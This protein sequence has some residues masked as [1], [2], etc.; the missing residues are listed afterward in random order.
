ME[1]HTGGGGGL[2]V[3]VSTSGQTID[4]S[5][6]RPADPRSAR[7][8]RPPLSMGCRPSVSRD[9]TFRGLGSASSAAG[10][11]GCGKTPQ[12]PPPPPRPRG[13]DLLGF[14]LVSRPARG[15]ASSGDL[16]WAGGGGVANSSSG[17]LWPGNTLRSG[18]FLP[19]LH[20]LI[21]IP[22]PSPTL[23]IT[24]RPL[25][26]PVACSLRHRMPPLGPPQ[27]RGGAGPARWHA[28]RVS[29]SAYPPP[30]GAFWQP[31]V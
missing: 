31:G 10:G 27:A 21:P 5:G 11:G 4:E 14:P 12:C 20:S 19:G 22:L 3:H 29:Q 6:G 28:E 1:C 2:A 30:P 16:T 8:K 15:A 13:T 25:S 9:S 26:V 24:W 7:G 23:I 17:N 18:W